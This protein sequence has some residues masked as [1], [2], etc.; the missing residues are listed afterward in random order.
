MK[1]M[2]LVVLAG[3]ALMWLLIV[4]LTA[5]QEYVLAQGHAIIENNPRH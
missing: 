1:R 2:V 5:L 3:M 4:P